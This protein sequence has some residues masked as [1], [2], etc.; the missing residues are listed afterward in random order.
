LGLIS[1]SKLN[2]SNNPYSNFNP[3]ATQPVCHMGKGI[4][5]M[6]A[7]S[8]LSPVSTGAVD[9]ISSGHDE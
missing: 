1:P 9:A 5:M 7:G 8:E 4:C 6:G 3:A 2:S